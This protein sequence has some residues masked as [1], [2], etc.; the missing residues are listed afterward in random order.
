MPRVCPSRKPYRKG[1]E[2]KVEGSNYRFRFFRRMPLLDATLVSLHGKGDGAEPVYVLVPIGTRNWHLSQWLSNHLDNLPIYSHSRVIETLKAKMYEFDYGSSRRMPYHFEL[3]YLGNTISRKQKHDGEVPDE[4]Q[5]RTEDVIA[6]MGHY[7]LLG[8]AGLCAR[9][10]QPTGDPL[11]RLF[12]GQPTPTGD[13]Q[14]ECAPPESETRYCPPGASIPGTCP[15]G[16]CEQSKQR[17]DPCYIGCSS[18]SA[19]GEAEVPTPRFSNDRDD[20]HIG[21]RRKHFQRK[22]WERDPDDFLYV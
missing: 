15:Y 16:G 11:A 9:T 8:G 17:T 14:T 19:L 1:D 3:A 22:P 5:E 7:G 4:P 13:R 20:P 2:I 21:K 6:R 18:P 10:H 12:E